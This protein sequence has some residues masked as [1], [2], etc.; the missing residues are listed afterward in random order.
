[1]TLISSI[2]PLVIW[3]KPLYVFRAFSLE[4][5]RAA[6]SLGAPMPGTQR[7]SPASSVRPGLAGATPLTWPVLLFLDVTST[8][9]STK[10]L[11]EILRP[12]SRFQTLFFNLPHLEAEPAD[13]SCSSDA[14]VH[15]SRVVGVCLSAPPFHLRLSVKDTRPGG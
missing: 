7:V 6:C 12:I 10:I 1:M 3:C 8:P 11:K 13:P 15:T 5:G 14:G 4:Q 9:P 2:A